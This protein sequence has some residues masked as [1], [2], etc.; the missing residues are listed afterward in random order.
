MFLV[1]FKFLDKF[2]QFLDEN[3]YKFKLVIF[4]VA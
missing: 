1:G 3:V 2:L 4:Y